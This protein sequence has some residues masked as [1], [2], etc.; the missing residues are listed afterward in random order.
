[1][2]FQ[3]DLLRV[4]VPCGRSLIGARLSPSPHRAP[5]LR[6]FSFEHTVT[7]TL[8]FVD[9]AGQVCRRR[10]LG[11]VLRGVRPTSEGSQAS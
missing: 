11:D 7:L 10:H 9:M 6:S 8:R 2:I 1:M 5:Q 4:Q 3:T